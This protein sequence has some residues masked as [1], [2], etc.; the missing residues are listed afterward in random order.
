MAAW[1]GGGGGEEG[2]EVIKKTILYSDIFGS[3]SG[4]RHNVQNT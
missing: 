4:T 3:V 1:G 2:G